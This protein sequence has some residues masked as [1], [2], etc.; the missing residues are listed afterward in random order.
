[1]D[2][3]VQTN[4]GKSDETLEKAAKYP[5][6]AGKV[7]LFTSG[8]FGLDLASARGKKSESDNRIEHLVCVDKSEKVECFWS[9]VSEIIIESS[10]IEAI[11]KIA[12]FLQANTKVISPKDNYCFGGKNL[13][14]LERTKSMMSGLRKN[15]EKGS[16]WLSSDE[17]FDHIKSIFKA[18]KFVFIR[19]DL[20][21]KE[22]TGTIARALK[23]QDL[24]LDCIYMSNVSEFAEKYYGLEKFRSAMAE[25]KLASREDTFFVDTA[26]R[27]GGGKIHNHER[28]EQRMRRGFFKTKVE[29]A[30]ESSPPCE[31]HHYD[32]LPFKVVA[33][34]ADE[35]LKFMQS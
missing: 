19:A 16:S 6:L 21:E 1:M 17:S 35:L 30:F 33:M 29:Y 18:R 27:V 5:V 25:F 24:F 8:F 32:S 22:A 4:E 20:C 23:E 34:S 28:L 9:K 15:I 31:Q 7:L 11:E 2:I 10:R 3:F 26:P 13:S 14:S 12:S